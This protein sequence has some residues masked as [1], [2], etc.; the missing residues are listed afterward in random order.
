MSTRLNRH[1]GIALFLA[2]AALLLHS[3]FASAEPITVTDD[4]GRSLRIEMPPQRIVSLAPGLTEILF[5][6]GLGDRIVGVTDYCNYPP[7]ALRKSKIGGLNP[8]IEA[9]LAL[10]PDLV[11]GVAGLFQQENLIRFERFHISY[12]VADPESVEK[13]FHTILILGKMTGALPTAEESVRQLR[14]R[15]ERIRR[16]VHSEIPPRLLY[17]VDAEPIISVGIN[18]YLNDLI[19]DAGAVNITGRIKKSYP[20]VSMEFVIRED[21]QVIILATDADLQLTE[22]QRRRWT[23][24]NTLSAVREGKIYK[25]NRDLLNRPGPRIVDGLEE[26]AALLHPSAVNGLGR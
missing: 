2:L 23:R 16:S 20:I 12:F 14:D 1:V 3:R 17:V 22:S 13:I 26:L 9:I 18:S 15:L 19:R 11:V 8:N 6:L 24:W 25:V 5:S 4:L 21:P 7:E 10:R